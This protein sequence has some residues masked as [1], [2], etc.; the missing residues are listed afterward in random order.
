MNLTNDSFLIITE[1]AKMTKLKILKNFS[2][3]CVSINLINGSFE[4]NRGVY[5]DQVFITNNFPSFL[6]VKQIS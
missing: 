4:E 5:A 3:F 6:L 2:A 1:G